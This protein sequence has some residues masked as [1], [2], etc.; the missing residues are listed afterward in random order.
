MNFFR[1][2]LFPVAAAVLLALL[3]LL[4]VETSHHHGAMESNDDCSVCSWQQAG[5]HAVTTPILP[6]IFFALVFAFLFTFE[7]LS[8]SFLFY[9][10]SGRSPPQ[11]LL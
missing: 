4:A 7:P 6:L 2:H 11:N 10:T 3:T 8:L 9:S 5:S 1:K